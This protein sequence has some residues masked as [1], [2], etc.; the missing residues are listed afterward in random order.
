MFDLEKLL[1]SPDMILTILS[2]LSYK[3]REELYKYKKIKEVSLINK[4]ELC[5]RIYKHYL[6][7]LSN[8]CYKKIHKMG[9]CTSGKSDV[10]IDSIFGTKEFLY[11]TE[12]EISTLFTTTKIN[13]ANFPEDFVCQYFDQIAYK[14]YI[15]DSEEIIHD[16]IEKHFF[17]REEEFLS[18]EKNLEY[19]LINIKVPDSLEY[20]PTIKHFLG[21]FKELVD[22]NYVSVIKCYSGISPQP[23][24][25]SIFIPSD[26]PV[27][28]L[29][30][31]GFS[32]VTKLIMR[33][34][35]FNPPAPNYTFSVL[36]WIPVMFVF[37]ESARIMD[38]ILTNCNPNSF[39]W[40]NIV[41]FKKISILGDS[42]V[43]N[44]SNLLNKG[45]FSFPRNIFMTNVS[46]S[47]IY[48][49]C[50][51]E[52]IEEIFCFLGINTKLI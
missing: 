28:N 6:H 4:E 43:N 23:K 1:T 10:D 27:E 25:K 2:E 45:L 7:I 20:H 31:Y 30:H 46:H 48:L 21:H 5:Y 13:M 38:C 49:G 24:T 47:K 8:N 19:Q 51:K 29:A 32:I 44:F 34:T 39:L 9:Y 26:T 36:E 17:R 22:G 41:V 33:N 37:N 3:K 40:G 14:S 18:Y 11:D 16:N 35:I 42:Y 15:L 50:I 52:N 12:I